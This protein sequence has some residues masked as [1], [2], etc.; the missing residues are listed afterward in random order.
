MS[1]R[2]AAWC[3]TGGGWVAC[4]GFDRWYQRAYISF[5]AEICLIVTASPVPL[6]MLCRALNV[7]G[8]QLLGIW[9]LLQ[10]T[11]LVVPAD[12]FAPCCIVAKLSPRETARAPH[13]AYLFCCAPLP[14]ASST[15]LKLVFF[16]LDLGGVLGL[17]LPLGGWAGLATASGHDFCPRGRPLPQGH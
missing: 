9:P 10:P 5:V 17:E 13:P 1:T 12:S 6:G 8:Q 15:A 7:S 2:W 11:S 16:L 4:P 3:S 14:L